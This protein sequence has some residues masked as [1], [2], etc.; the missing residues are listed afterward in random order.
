MSEAK[1]D[2]SFPLS[3]FAIEGF[4]TPFRLDRNG[5]GGGIIIYIIS[6][7]PCK[8]MKNHLPDNTEGIF[9]E[10]NLRKKE[11]I[12]FGGYN[13]K[14]ECM[15]N[16]LN[17]IGKELDKCIG[18]Y[19]N[20]LLVGD[21]NSE[22]EEE[23]MTD[24]CD[25]Y[26]LQNLIKYPTCF[27]SVQNPT[28]INMNLTNRC[29]CFQNT[30]TIQTGISDHQKMIIT[31]LKTFFTKSELNQSLHSSNKLNMKYDDFKQIFMRVLN[32]HAPM[33]VKTIRG[34]N[35]PFMNKSLSKSIMVRSKLKNRYN[36][37]PTEQNKG[38]YNK[39]RKYS[40]NLAKKVK[41]DY[42]NNL[43]LNIFKDNKTFWKNIRPL[44]SEKQ[45]GLQHEFILV[46]NDEVISDEQDFAEKM[47]NL[48]V[49]VTENLG[50]EP[51]NELHYHYH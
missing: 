6:D 25:I 3:Q 29:V 47:N 19:D 16:F 45:K 10:L 5:G 49:D 9:I 44:F 20:M 41:K 15:P 12:L 35:A 4:S 50:I 18:N 42:Y 32:R 7:I 17:Q 43:D 1:I 8:E 14:K 37:F 34:N 39:Q 51:E 27:K 21:F 36:K 13:P 40:T 33:K 11:W 30:C 28:S 48:F 26:N 22:M 38:L 2:E 46:E 24:F 31:V 23:N